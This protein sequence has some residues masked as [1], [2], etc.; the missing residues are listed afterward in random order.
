MVFVTEPI[1]NLPSAGGHWAGHADLSG[2]VDARRGDDNAG[3]AEQAGEGFDQRL[4]CILSPWDQGRGCP[5][6]RVRA[7]ELERPLVEFL[8]DLINGCVRAA[9]E[10]DYFRAVDSLG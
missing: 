9:A 4:S 8:G 7:E 10:D 6:A 2:L 3:G 5:L 1:S